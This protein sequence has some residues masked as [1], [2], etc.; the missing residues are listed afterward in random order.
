MEHRLEER[1]AL[2]LLGHALDTA[3]ADGRNQREIPAFWAAH[4]RGPRQAML[5]ALGRR[6]APE[7]GAVAR[8]DAHSGAM[9]Y[10]IGMEAGPDLGAAPPGLTWLVLPAGRYAV[11]RSRPAASE[12]EFLAAIPAL[13]GEAMAWLPGSGLQP[14][15]APSFEY[16]D[17]HARPDAAPRRFMELWLPVA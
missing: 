13:W 4:D 11:L 14:R 7:Y 5:A 16:Y 17:G 6:D 1:P 2:R 9:R 3:L 12:A 8:F 10:F 15:E